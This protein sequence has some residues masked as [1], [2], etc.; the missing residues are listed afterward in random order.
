M[1][2]YFQEAMALAHGQAQALT[3]E[4]IA[5]KAM[6]GECICQEPNRF[7]FPCPVHQVKACCE[8]EAAHA[9]L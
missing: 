4:R 1:N 3:L 8:G 9:G 5:F 7:C 2:P 6:T